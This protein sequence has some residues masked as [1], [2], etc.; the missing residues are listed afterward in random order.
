MR[1]DPEQFDLAEALARVPRPR[2]PSLGVRLWYSRYAVLPGGVLPAGLVELGIATDPAAPVG[3]VAAAGVAYATTPGI[4]RWVL[5]WT[6]C[7]RV[8]RAVRKTFWRG[9]ICGPDGRV[10][11][12]RSA[13][14]T[15]NGVKVDVRC[16]IG[17]RPARV[18]KAVDRIQDATGASE[19]VALREPGR[20]KV[21]VGLTFES[22]GRW[23]EG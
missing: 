22:R 12:V 16:P 3:V 7:I 5:R 15:P 23:C 18:V 14:P 6:R 21:A 2:R 4:R 20:R 10:P 13:T 1:P 11:V 19:V 8:D 17:M 9:R